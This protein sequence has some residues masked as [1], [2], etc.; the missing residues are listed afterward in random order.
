MERI[1]NRSN[2]GTGL[3]VAAVLVAAAVLVLRAGEI[4]SRKIEPVPRA[5]QNWPPAPYMEDIFP[6]LSDPPISVETISG[7]N[8]SNAGK[9]ARRPAP[10][11]NPTCR[12]DLD[13]PAARARR[14]ATKLH[15]MFLEPNIVKCAIAKL[16]LA[17]VQYL[18]LDDDT[19]WTPNPPA[20]KK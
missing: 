8:G 11:A 6:A 3:F 13:S 14:L 18:P 2:L 20:T 5:G 10:S 1:K 15:T 19:A 7:L 12:A 4:E 9:F 17:I 16:Y